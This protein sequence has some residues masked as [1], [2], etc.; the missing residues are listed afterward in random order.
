LKFF[1]KFK[2]DFFSRLWLIGFILALTCLCFT[3]VPACGQ[4]NVNK[5]S[6]PDGPKGFNDPKQ[7]VEALIDAAG[8]FDVGALIS[9]FG[10]ENEDIVLTGEDPQDRQR[11]ADFVAAAR[12]K[13][14]I[15]T[16]PKNKN[17]AFLRVGN[18]SWPFPIPLVKNGA[19][20]FFDGKAGRQEILYRRIGFNELAAID[21]CQNY[22]EAQQEYA[23]RKRD[24]YEVHQY[25]QRVIS[26]P[27][28]QDGLAW[29]NSDGSWGG[30]IGQNIARAI[31][32]GYK[33]GDEPYKGY[34]FKVLK[35]QGPNAPL[36]ELDFVVKGVM[37]G[38]FALAATPAQYEVT[39]VNTFI[40]SQDGIVYQ[41][42]LG[43]GSLDQFN[44]MERFNPD[45]SWAPVQ[46]K[47]EE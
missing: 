10:A 43:K 39:G 26:T 38:G 2:D 3:V 1:F 13:T 7:A 19:Q 20:W 17:R 34:F 32:Q 47:T 16:E 24:G 27:G 31:E 4:S 37:I 22:V 8:K 46:D 44:K 15:S 12:E 18:E 45:K 33:S 30:P 42:D 25:A 40:V 6:T 14:S 35:G 5:S 28:K 21:I 36:G 29:K 11:A 23:F 41:K 9:I